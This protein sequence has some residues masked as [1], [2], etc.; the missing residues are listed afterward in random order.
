[1]KLDACL[2]ILS[3]NDA[4]DYMGR[5]N[6]IASYE[7]NDRELEIPRFLPRFLD[8]AMRV[9]DEYASMKNARSRVMEFLN[10]CSKRLLR[11]G[12]MKLCILFVLSDCRSS[13]VEDIRCQRRL[14]WPESTSSRSWKRLLKHCG[15]PFKRQRHQCELRGCIRRHAVASRC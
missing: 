4:F 3:L 11:T 8:Y 7:E 9:W 6:H 5:F 14:W 12:R 1:M 13:S 10:L 15:P 2:A